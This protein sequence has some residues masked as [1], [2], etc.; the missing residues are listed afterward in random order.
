M[1]LSERSIV[2]GTSGH[3]SRHVM[4]AFPFQNTFEVI[5]IER[6]GGITCCILH[7]LYL[8]QGLGISNSLL[9]LIIKGDTTHS[10]SVRLQPL[11]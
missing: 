10:C 4:V 3:G 7:V 11:T 5:R 9:E 2:P 8:R 1:D 6:Q